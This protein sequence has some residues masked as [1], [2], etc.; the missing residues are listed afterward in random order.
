MK[1]C[2]LGGTMMPIHYT[3]LVIFAVAFAL[4]GATTGIENTIAA[5]AEVTITCPATMNL[6]ITNPPG[7]WNSIPIWVQFSESSVEPSL[8]V[9]ACSYDKRY[10]ITREFPTGMMCQASGRL[11]HCNPVKPPIKIKNK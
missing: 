7:G 6:G 9:I 4:G 1:G 5:P 8:K 3:T 11:I 10:S 2:Y